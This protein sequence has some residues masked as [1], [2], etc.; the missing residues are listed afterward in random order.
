MARTG[1]YEGEEDCGE[2]GVNRIARE[3]HVGVIESLDY[4]LVP[5]IQGDSAYTN[6][7]FGWAH[8]RHRFVC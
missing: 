7:Y 4:K 1:I 2:S 8:L 6:E 5:V 3:P